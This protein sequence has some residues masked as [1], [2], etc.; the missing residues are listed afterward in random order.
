MATTKRKPRGSLVPSQGSTPAPK[1]PDQDVAQS[2][3][4]DEDIKELKKRLAAAER[5]KKNKKKKSKD[6]VAAK[7]AAAER[8]W[9]RSSTNGTSPPP[10][11]LSDASPEPRQRKPRSDEEYESGKDGGRSSDQDSIPAATT[12][13]GKK[14]SPK[15]RKRSS[16][17]DSGDDGKDGDN[18]HEAEGNRSKKTNTTTATPGPQVVV[19]ETR[20]VRTTVSGAPRAKRAKVV[21]KPSMGPSPATEQPPST[22]ANTSRVKALVDSQGNP[23]TPYERKVNPRA[24][25]K[26][27][28]DDFSPSSRDLTNDLRIDFVVAMMTK[29]AFMTEQEAIAAVDGLLKVRVEKAEP[30]SKLERRGIRYDSVEEARQDYR[31]AVKNVAPAFRGHCV[32][33]AEG[34]IKPKFIDPLLRKFKKVDERKEAVVKLTT[35]G[36]FHFEDPEK[37]EG[38]LANE[39]VPDLFAAVFLRPKS[40]GKNRQPLAFGPHLATFKPVPNHLLAFLVTA[41]ECALR[42]W[43]TGA[44]VDELFQAKVYDK[45]Y[46]DHLSSI[47]KIEFQ[48]PDYMRELK[49]DIWTSACESAGVQA[50]IIV[51]EDDDTGYVDDD[52]VETLTRRK[53][54]TAD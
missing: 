39:I 15:K 7:E 45:I 40:G 18:E 22:P 53:K 51:W 2:S 5:K 20:D 46:D 43:S 9:L 26:P 28:G 42:H 52:A 8:E 31:N 38:F 34:L 30:G 41:I 54:T 14:K 37:R 25:N 12:R 24:P 33:A 21:E 3:E 35:K 49:E 10:I 47:E 17:A 13:G 6:A 48:A 4:D 29:N 1:T 23:V 36:A 11:E 19:G 44:F 16:N 32:E 27:R 50:S